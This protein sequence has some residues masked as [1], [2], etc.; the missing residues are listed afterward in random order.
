VKVVVCGGRDYAD[1]QRVFDVLTRKDAY[2][3]VT[4]LAHGGARGADSHAEAWRV[5]RGVE[6]CVYLP[7]WNRHGKAAGP[8]RNRLMLDAEKPDCVIAFPG[9]RGTDDCVR[10]ARERGIPVLEVTDDHSSR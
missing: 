2:S 3:P 8:I 5:D 10:A 7:D 9:G 6:G 4:R 1:R